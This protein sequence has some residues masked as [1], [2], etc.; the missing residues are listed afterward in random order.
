METPI[1]LQLE[2]TTACNSDCVM[3]PRRELIRKQ[4][5]ISEDFAKKIV[6][7][8]ASLGIKMMKPQWFGESLLVP[9]WHKIVKYAKKQGMRIMLI[10]NGSRLTPANRKKVINLV[11]KIIISID[12]HKRDVYEKIRRGLKFD[13]V[14]SNITDLYNERNKAKSNLKII[15]SAVA[16]KENENELKEF[17]EFFKKISDHIIINEDNVN[18]EWDGKIRD[19]VCYHGVD[20]RL[21]V[22]WSGT[23]YLCCHDWL[24]KYDIGSLKEYSIKEVWNGKRRLE[25]LRNLKE[26]D[27][28]QQCVWSL[29]QRP[30]VV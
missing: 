21:V 18:I 22:D 23:C 29:E 27:I 30:K 12:S 24:G 5:T 16:I 9:Y 17:K 7:E 14:V 26:L 1:E 28:C 25:Y 2:L 11:D 20:K 6:K 13:E 10:T 19:I 3:C 4:G 15:V 8:A